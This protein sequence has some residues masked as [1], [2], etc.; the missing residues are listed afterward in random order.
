MH[1]DLSQREIELILR[2]LTE[3]SG[4]ATAGGQ[5][6]DPI[7]ALVR[8]LELRTPDTIDPDEAGQTDR[9]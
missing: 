8:K 3:M 7:D 1:L 4:R 9:A 6:A 2:A 5:S